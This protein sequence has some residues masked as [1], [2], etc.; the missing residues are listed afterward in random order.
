MRSNM[1]SYD[2]HLQANRS[3]YLDKAHLQE[4]VNTEFSSRGNI[5]PDRELSCGC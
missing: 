4:A 3:I 1:L 2:L 5:V